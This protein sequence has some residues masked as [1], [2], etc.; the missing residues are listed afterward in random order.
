MHLQK[1]HFARI[2]LLIFGLMMFRNILPT[3]LGGAEYCGEFSHIH[4]FQVRS[5]FVASKSAN[6]QKSSSIDQ[7][8]DLINSKFGN[9]TLFMASTKD[10][11]HS[12]KSRISFNHVPSLEDELDEAES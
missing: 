1:K 4:R 10:V 12:A 2:L 6:S 8:M 5:S 3:D 9:N 11:I 7:A